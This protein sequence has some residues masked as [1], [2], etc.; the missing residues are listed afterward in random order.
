MRCRTITRYAPQCYDSD[1]EME[2]IGELQT[3]ASRQALLE[4]Q[5]QARV[6]A[7]LQKLQS[8]QSAALSKA[9]EAIASAS[10][11]PKDNEKSRDGV[12]AQVQ[13]LRKQLEA[14]KQIKNLPEGV[15]TA[16]GEVI[17]CLR[18]NDRR[19]L[20]CWAEVE[21]FKKEV[22]KMEQEWVNKVVS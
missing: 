16:R 15:E 7:E 21:S 13:E 2:L 8:Q 1:C 19:P 9:H 11:E 20:D 17:R 3:D 18:E 14:R 12:N 5:I 6:H 4:A 22:K 10:P